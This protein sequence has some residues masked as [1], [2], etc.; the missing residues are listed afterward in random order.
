M[1]FDKEKVERMRQ[2]YPKGTR[3]EL[4]Y[5]DDEYSRLKSGDMGT[6]VGVDDAGQIMMNWDC[7]SSLS[8]IPG[9]D[10]F[11][12]VKEN[13]IDDVEDLEL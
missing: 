12:I 3:I 2:S 11:R 9:V 5:M 1:F 8:L 6:V 4:S 7:H 13:L 10:S